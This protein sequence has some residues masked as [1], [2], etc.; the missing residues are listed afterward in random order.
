MSIRSLLPQ[1]IHHQKYYINSLLYYH[2]EMKRMAV[3]VAVCVQ[4]SVCLSIYLFIYSPPVRT[5][6]H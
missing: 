2:R 5:V 4:L 3:C 6:Q 1:T